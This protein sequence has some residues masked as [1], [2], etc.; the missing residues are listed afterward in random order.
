MDTQQIALTS[1]RGEQH[2]IALKRLY[3]WLTYER[4]SIFTFLVMFGGVPFAP[5]VLILSI[6]ALLFTPFMLRI[7]I[8]TQHWGWV[9]AFAIIVGIPCVLLF[10]PVENRILDAALR[11]L[12]LFTFYLYCWLLRMKAEEWMEEL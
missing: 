9:K 7:L 8:Q 3:Y 10:I 1:L 12:P 4:S 6:A 5:L 11:F 2:R